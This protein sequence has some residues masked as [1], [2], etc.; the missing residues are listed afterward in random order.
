MQKWPA[1]RDAIVAVGTEPAGSDL[2][3][4]T[5]GAPVDGPARALAEEPRTHG[6]TLITVHE[7]YP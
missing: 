6:P 7:E 4:P 5:D 2:R 3:P 1:G